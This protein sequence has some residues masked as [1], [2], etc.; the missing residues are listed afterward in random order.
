MVE[1]MKLAVLLPFWGMSSVWWARAYAV[2]GQCLA[3]PGTG[4][5]GT[6][7][8]MEGHRPTRRSMGRDRFLRWPR[9]L[10][11]GSGLLSGRALLGLQK[12]HN[13]SLRCTGDASFSPSPIAESLLRALQ[14][15]P[16]ALQICQKQGMGRALW[17][18]EPLT[19]RC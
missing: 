1:A 11:G 7:G 18:G 17:A 12:A 13:T 10:G 3:A 6:G 2:V 9:R 14:Q 5:L 15:G 8:G 16:E 19:K 4:G